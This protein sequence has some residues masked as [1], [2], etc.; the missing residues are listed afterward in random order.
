MDFLFTGEFRK[1]LTESKME[2][3]ETAGELTSKYILFMP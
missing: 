1:K 3:L 2:I